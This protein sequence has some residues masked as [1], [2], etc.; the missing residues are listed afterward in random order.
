MHKR[1]L[2]DAITGHDG[3][4]SDEFF[5]DNGCHVQGTRRRFSFGNLFLDSSRP[6]GASRKLLYTSQLGA[7]G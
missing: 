5:L 4:Y 1:A 3:V 7:P 6:D 2:I